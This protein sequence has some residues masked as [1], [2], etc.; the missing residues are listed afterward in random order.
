[1]WKLVVRCWELL[2]GSFRMGVVGWERLF[3]SLHLRGV[4]MCTGAFVWVLPSGSFWLGVC[5]F[6]GFQV[7]T[8]GTLLGA[9]G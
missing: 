4:G 1:M 9:D 2:A 6:E 5:V 3:G 8:F 7:E